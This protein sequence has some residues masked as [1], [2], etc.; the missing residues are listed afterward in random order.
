MFAHKNTVTRMSLELCILAS[1]S[2]GNAA[3][4]RTPAGAILIDAGIGPRTIAKRMCGTGVS[5]SDVRAICLTHL[6]R[7]HFSPT[8]FR[9][10]QKMGIRLLCHENRIEELRQDEIPI[11]PFNGVCFE[12][13]SGVRFRALP[14]AHDEHGS[15]GFI[16]EGFGCRIGYATDLGRVPKGLLD[17]FC[18]VDVLA[19]ESNYDTEMELRSA[20]PWFLKQR[21]MGGKGHLSNQQAFDAIRA[22]LGRCRQL[23]QHIV[24]LHRSRECNCPKLLR[25]LFES[26]KRIGP[27]LTLAEQ[28]ERT[29]WLRVRAPS[30]WMGEQLLL[31]LGNSS[32]Y[33]MPAP[34]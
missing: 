31:P 20:R 3:L 23:P 16:I 27:R 11:E 33:A 5:I 10:I 9:T 1:G 22:I 2:G 12:P 13:I 4:L 21:I 14:L 34:A 15:H 25:K 30:P 32:A 26:D 17:A 8:W 24:L 29:E 19:L 18:G 28:F 6:D 7:D